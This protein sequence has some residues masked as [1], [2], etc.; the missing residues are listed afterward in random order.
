MST[1][2]SVFVFETNKRGI[3]GKFC[4]H[5]MGSCTSLLRYF[6]NNTGISIRKMMY[7]NIIDHA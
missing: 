6:F 2:Y 4:R 7:T 1:D 5:L 3:Y